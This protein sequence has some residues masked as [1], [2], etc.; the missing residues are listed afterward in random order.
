MTPRVLVSTSSFLDTPG[1]HVEKLHRTGYEIV[2]ARG[3]LQEEDLLRIISSGSAFDGFLCGEDEFTAKVI[4]DIAPRAKV[5]S[6]YG[7]GL[8]KIDVAEAIHWTRWL[9][10]Y[11]SCRVF[12]NVCE[13][14][15]GRWRRMLIV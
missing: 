10:S 14:S 2:S 4:Q 1:L 12:N 7:V 5:I 15:I 6:K 3:P 13:H 9:V 8:D 11:G